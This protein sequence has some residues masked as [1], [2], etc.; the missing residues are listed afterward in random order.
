AQVSYNGDLLLRWVVAQ[1]RVISEGPF[2]NHV[3]SGRATWPAMVTDARTRRAALLLRR[4]LLVF[5]GTKTSRNMRSAAQ[6]GFMK[7]VCH[8]FQ[9]ERIYE[10]VR[11]AGYRTFLPEE[12]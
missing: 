3:T 8:S 11:P 7:G 12:V 10:G 9:P 5:Y 6:L 1:H 4:A 2:L